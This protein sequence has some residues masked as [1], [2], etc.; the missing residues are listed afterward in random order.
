MQKN[1]S[2]TDRTI[3][4]VVGV[5]IFYLAYSVFNGAVAFLGY[6]VGVVLLVTAFTG[7]CAAYKLF[8][9]DTRR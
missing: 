7:F 6:V 3:R 4:A 9:I 1:E 2:T 8:G 5:I